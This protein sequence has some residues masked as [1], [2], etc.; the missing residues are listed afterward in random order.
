MEDE[1]EKFYRYR[2]LDYVQ[3]IAA[4]HPDTHRSAVLGQMIAEHDRRE[5]LIAKE[6]VKVLDMAR[7]LLLSPT[8]VLFEVSVKQ[9]GEFLARNANHPVTKLTADFLTE[10]IDSGSADNSWQR[11]IGAESQQGSV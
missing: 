3:R 11:L 4:E 8:P 9:I 7:D 2:W 1:S 6:A 10:M 5:E